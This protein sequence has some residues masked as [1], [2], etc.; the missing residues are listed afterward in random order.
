MRSVGS[1]I[2]FLACCT[3]SLALSS[4]S[5]MSDTYSDDSLTAPV[6]AANYPTGYGSR[7]PTQIETKE[8]VIVV[9][10]NVHTWGA[11]DS[12]GNLVRSGLA[13]AGSSWCPDI[14]RPCKTKAG[15]FRIQSLG[16]ADCKSSIYP[17]PKGGAPMPYCMFFNG[18]QGLHGSGEVVE[19][20]IS[21]GCVRMHV[22]DAEWLRFD[23]A[24]TGTKVIVKPY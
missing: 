15:H 16:S 21:H 22:S 18:N 6:Y 9:D 5:S 19:G 8:K 4:C 10:P 14:G 23:F 2:S 7:L 12:G 1:G 11:Y 3:V 13:T 20:N 17:L 24:K